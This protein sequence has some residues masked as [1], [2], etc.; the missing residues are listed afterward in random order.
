M[1]EKQIGFWWL[2]RTGVALMGYFSYLM[3]HKR[4]KV[5]KSGPVKAGT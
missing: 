4:Y 5:K 2:A 1:L 3:A